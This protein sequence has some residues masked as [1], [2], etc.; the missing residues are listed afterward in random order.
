MIDLL[1]IEV[2]KIS[3]Y[4]V[5]WILIGVYALLVPLGFLGVCNLIMEIQEPF[6][7]D[8]NF[9]AFPKVWKFIAW[10]S[11]W[12]SF[13]L[14]ILVIILFCNEL[15]FRTQRQNI[16]D[17]MSRGQFVAGKCFFLSFLALMVSLYTT[18][19][20]A[21]FGLWDGG[22]LNFVKDIGFM[23]IYFIQTLGYFS[24]AFLFYIVNSFFRLVLYIVI[25]A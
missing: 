13:L 22:S 12:W 3:R 9:S 16:I 15:T 24:V 6:G 5:F 23:G 2:A 25:S 19:V 17:G 1:K 8:V 20:G 11:A 18:I 21:I 4:R 7:L 10:T 14:G